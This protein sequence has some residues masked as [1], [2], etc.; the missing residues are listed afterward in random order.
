VQYI[1]PSLSTC[2]HPE[3]YLLLLHS[4]SF[5]PT[6]PQGATYVLDL[7][8][9]AIGRVIGKGGETIKALQTS[10]G[11]SIQV[12]HSGEGPTKRITI[13]GSTQA[14]VDDAKK[15]I[16]ELAEH[17]GGESP[18]TPA[19]AAAAAAAA[20]HPH[21]QYPP[22]ITAEQQQSPQQQQQQQQQPHAQH[23]ECPQSLVGRIIGRGG[24]TIRALQSA[25]GA[26]ISINQNLPEGQPRIIE[27][28]GDE[29]SCSKAKI[30]ITELIAGE[31]GSAQAV[32]QKVITKHG[33]GK[34]QVLLAPKLMVGKVIG[35]GGEVIKQIQKKSGAT[36]QIDQSMDPCHVTVAGQEGAVDMAAYIIDS[37]LRGGDPYSIM[38]I[39]PSGPGGPGIGMGGGGYPMGG[40][41]VVS[42]SGPGGMMMM[43][44]PGGGG[45]GP[46]PGGYYGA[47][48]QPYGGGGGGM[49]PPQVTPPGGILEPRQGGGGVGYI[50]L[51]PQQQQQFPYGGA[52]PG[53]QGGGYQPPYSYPGSGGGGGGGLDGGGGGGY[54]QQQH[55][56]QLPPHPVVSGP[57]QE[58]R[59]NEGRA[60]YYN[61]QSG[62]TQWE[63]PREF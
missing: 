59:D 43:G 18:L 35:R 49:P 36:I 37:I 45:G 63:K 27:I 33:F 19:S 60:Y 42:S 58:L 13:A 38:N 57:W 56:Q 44:G 40:G 51:A 22:P 15:Q 62:T 1:P 30:M 50:S 28:S 11:A 48:Q 2:S 14:V 7:P 6:I 21:G 53:P 25:S 3:P 17:S 10:T 39:G 9:T 54:Q 16:I 52:G 8:T 32:I 29:D 4:L 46:P 47:P 5:P 34:S 41:P 31:Q 61:S 24:E 20:G 23:M 26:H 12:D 55:H